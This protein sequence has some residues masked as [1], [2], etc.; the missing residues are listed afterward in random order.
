MPVCP[1]RASASAVGSSSAVRTPSS[2]TSHVPSGACRPRAASTARRVLPTPAGPTTV[3]RRCPS[4]A[5]RTAASS[6]ARPTSAVV[7]AGRLP[8]GGPPSA[9]SWTSTWCARPGQRGPGVDAQLVGQH[10]GDA[11]V[12]GQRVGR[13]P[14]PV[15]RRDQQRPQPLAQRVLRDQRLQLADQLARRPEREPRRQ[16]VL[17]QPQPGLGQPHPVR[18]HPVAVARGGQHLGVEELQAR[19]AGGGRGGGVAVGEPGRA[20]GGEP[21]GVQRV[22][23]VG[24]ER[25]ARGPARTRRPGR[26]APGAVARP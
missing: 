19:P 5:A 9:G 6:A 7:G 8:R 24:G 11:A 25:V 26:P 3:T 23:G 10:P 1:G 18:R 15:Q 4:S 20:L 2:R 22:D 17:G 12:R 14:R 21:G 13:A 16:L